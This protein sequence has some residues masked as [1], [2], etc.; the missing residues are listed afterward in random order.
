MR[1]YEKVGGCIGV[2][3]GCGCRSWVQNVY[4]VANTSS[5]SYNFTQMLHTSNALILTHCTLILPPASSPTPIPVQAGIN[6]VRAAEISHN[7]FLH[8]DQVHWYSF[9]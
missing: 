1:F 7:K 3:G 5:S 4:A 9:N 6:G 2:A 8:E